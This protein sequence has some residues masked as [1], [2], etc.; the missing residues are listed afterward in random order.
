[1]KPITSDQY[2]LP[3]K[4]PRHP[5]TNKDKVQRVF[6]VEKPHWEDQLRSCMAELVNS[7]EQDLRAK[8][9]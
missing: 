5:V 8:T 7:G 4:R 1:M 2:P 3:A 6:G 9:L